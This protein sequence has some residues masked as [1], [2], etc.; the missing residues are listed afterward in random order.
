MDIF[1]TWNF[2]SKASSET[3]VHI[4]TANVRRGATSQRLLTEGGHTQSTDEC[5]YRSWKKQ[6][7]VYVWLMYNVYD[8]LW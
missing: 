3:Y 8:K 5:A 6:A 1:L 2:T 7:D 4:S